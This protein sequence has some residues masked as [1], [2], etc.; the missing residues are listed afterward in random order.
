MIRFDIINNNFN[1]KCDVTFLD[2]KD[3]ISTYEFKCDFEEAILPKE[4]SL[5]FDIPFGGAF[6]TWNYSCIQDRRLIGHWRGNVQKVNS[7][8]SLGLP[9]L[10]I[11]S[12]DENNVFTVSVNDIKTPLQLKAGVND[13]RLCHYC[14]ITFFTNMSGSIKNYKTVIR[15]DKRQLNFADV[16]SDT[17]DTLRH[18]NGLEQSD[19]PIAATKAVFST[20]YNYHKDINEEKLLSQCTNAYNLGMRT[21]IVD[22]GWQMDNT[23]GGFAYCGDWNPGTGKFPDMKSFVEKVHKSGLK[24]VLWYSVPFVG[25]HSKAWKRFEGKF[26]DDPS[27][28]W[29]RLDPR[30]PDVRDYLINTYETAIKEW[31]VDGF[32]LDFIDEFVLTSFSDK[33]SNKRDYDSLEEAV[34][35]LLCETFKRLRAIKPDILI[36]FRQSYIGPIITSYANMVRVGDCA[37]DAITNR[38]GVLDLRLTS[39]KTIVHSDMVI[40]DYKDEAHIAAK[41][42]SAVLFGV[43]QVSVEFNRLPDEQYKM[44]KNYLE[45]FDS[46]ADTLLFGKLSIRN[47][48][49]GYSMAEAENEKEKIS[50]CYSRNVVDLRKG[51]HFIVNGTGDTEIIVKSE[52]KVSVKYVISDCMGNVKK[53]GEKLIDGI[54]YFNVPES[55]FLEIKE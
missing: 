27:Q 32:K 55:G 41:Q 46:H 19:A 12:Q 8:L 42:L 29:C 2:D 1:G 35:A 14:V 26:L 28:D 36:E 53:N 50:V 5:C 21:I 33:D 7:R 4:I 47:P 48:E 44:L 31:D 40:W 22:D 20:W 54:T 6:S 3:G 38:I 34:E 15:I 23:Y 52:E 16:I 13:S 37:M 51:V 17:V 24:V 49:C 45:F 10:S 39:G 9:V 25:K 43:P 11:I 18:V 30:F